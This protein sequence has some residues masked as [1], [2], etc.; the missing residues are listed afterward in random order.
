[1]DLASSLVVFWL[2][3]GGGTRAP[4]STITR[5]GRCGTLPRERCF[6]PYSLGLVAIVLLF[7]SGAS[8]LNA[9]RMTTTASAA[10]SPGQPALLNTLSFFGLLLIMSGDRPCLE[11]GELVKAL[12]LSW[13]GLPP[14]LFTPAPRRGILSCMP[15]VKGCHVECRRTSS[16]NSKF[17]LM[18][19][20]SVTWILGL[21]GLTG[22][23]HNIE[24][25]VSNGCSLSFGHSVTMAYCLCLFMFKTCARLLFAFV[26][27]LS[28]RSWSPADTG[29]LSQEPPIQAAQETILTC[30]FPCLPPSDEESLLVAGI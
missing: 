27:F 17:Q 21:M 30:Q 26:S 16:F 7:V 5:R 14:A 20:T 25:A 1:M 23:C 13:T 19:I 18:L 3:G 2:T 4:P 28:Y 8:L 6:L 29:T 24:F 10:P 15:G 12:R 11:F 9:H 22:C